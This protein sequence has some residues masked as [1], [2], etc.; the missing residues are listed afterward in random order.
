[1][2]SVINLWGKLPLGFVGL[3]AEE[4]TS[5]AFENNVASQAI[6]RVTSQVAA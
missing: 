4:A 6:S 5:G 1:M 3:G 2:A